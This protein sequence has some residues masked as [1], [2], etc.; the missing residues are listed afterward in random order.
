MTAAVHM[1]DLVTCTKCKC[2][3][4]R[5]RFSLDAKKKNGLRSW[6][7]DCTSEAAK[8]SAIKK[9]KGTGISSRVRSPFGYGFEF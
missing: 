1:D 4:E 9:R 3:K 8:Q 2:D 5:W 7:R 6:C